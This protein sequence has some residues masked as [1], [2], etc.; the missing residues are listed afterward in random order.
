MRERQRWRERLVPLLVLVFTF[1]LLAWGV[2]PDVDDGSDAPA[3]GTATAH[4]APTPAARAAV[5]AAPRAAAPRP[6]L[7]ILATTPIDVDVADL[8]HGGSQ[9][10][11]KLR[12]LGAP[13]HTGP[14]VVDTWSPPWLG[15]DRTGPPPGAVR[16]VLDVVAPRLG[17]APPFSRVS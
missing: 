13:G 17:R 7:A 12:T 2:A 8:R 14:A 1:G 16:P 3:V 10:A 9:A 15:A 11:D 4:A 6:V 5:S